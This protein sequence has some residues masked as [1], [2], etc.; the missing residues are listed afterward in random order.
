M[1][2]LQYKMHNLTLQVC[3]DKLQIR[4]V[5]GN[6]PG[7]CHDSFI[8]NSSELDTELERRF[9]NGEENTWLLGNFYQ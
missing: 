4:F 8:F 6:H 2:Y 7:S 9:E 5:D 1:I 3:D